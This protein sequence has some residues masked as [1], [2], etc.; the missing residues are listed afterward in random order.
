MSRI[1]VFDGVAYVSL[2]ELPGLLDDIAA[3]N[4]QRGYKQGCRDSEANCVEQAVGLGG[5][6]NI[7]GDGR[8]VIGEKRGAVSGPTPIGLSGQQ[9]T[10]RYE[11]QRPQSADAENQ[12]W[13]G[14]RD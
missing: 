5:R 10:A 7:L 9:I 8:V 12:Q 13:P 14:S 11:T 1:N 6:S 4:Y 3:G 2:H